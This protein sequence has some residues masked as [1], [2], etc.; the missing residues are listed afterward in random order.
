MESTKWLEALREKNSLLRRQTKRIDFLEEKFSELRKKYFR[1][2]YAHVI[3][4]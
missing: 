3:I 1:L 4:H 2:K